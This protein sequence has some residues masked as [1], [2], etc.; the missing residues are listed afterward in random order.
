MII[1]SVIGVFNSCFCWSLARW[2]GES[3]AVM[4]V[5]TRGRYL[6]YKKNLYPALVG[7]FV[8]LQLE[9]VAMFVVLLWKGLGVVR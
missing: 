8:A 2:V 1:A 9:F 6:S 4:V 3:A 5:N 7:T